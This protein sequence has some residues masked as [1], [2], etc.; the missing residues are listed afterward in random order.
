MPQLL[1]FPLVLEQESWNNWPN[2]PE[3][4]TDC[5]HVNLASRNLIVLW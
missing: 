5:K 4:R 2:R 3:T 1:N